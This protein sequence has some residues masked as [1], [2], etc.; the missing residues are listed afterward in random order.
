MLTLRNIVEAG[1]FQEG[2][3]RQEALLRLENAR[4]VVLHRR[5]VR[6]EALHMVAFARPAALQAGDAGLA[7][8]RKNR[9]SNN[10]QEFIVLLKMEVINRK[11]VTQ[12]IAEVESGYSAFA[13]HKFKRVY[14]LF[15]NF[16]KS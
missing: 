2:N 15:Y 10:I 5:N 14:V 9:C 4:Q 1:A 3:A 16:R 12:I 8:C 6:Q 11:T 7:V 13:F